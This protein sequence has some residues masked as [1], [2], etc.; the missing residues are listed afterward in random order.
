MRW[1]IDYSLGFSAALKEMF[2]W[3]VVCSSTWL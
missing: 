1:L 2:I 3:S